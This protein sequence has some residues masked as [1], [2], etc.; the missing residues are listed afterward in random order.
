MGP[1][2]HLGIPMRRLKLPAIVLGE[3]LGRRQTPRYPDMDIKKN[4]DTLDY[5][6]NDRV[7]RVST[8]LKN[9]VFQWPITSRRY[10][11]STISRFVCW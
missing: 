2:M 4:L 7:I 5:V 3:K 6:A 10:R 1:V 8:D 11:R 9:G